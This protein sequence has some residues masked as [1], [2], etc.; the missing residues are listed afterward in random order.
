MLYATHSPVVPYSGGWFVCSV[1]GVGR[2]LGWWCRGVLLSAPLPSSESKRDSA[3]VE[4][5]PHPR[6]PHGD[7]EAT[8]RQ[9]KRSKRKEASEE[10][11]THTRPA[12][13]LQFA[14]YCDLRV[15]SADRTTPID[16]ADSDHQESHRVSK[17][18][19]SIVITTMEH[20]PS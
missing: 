20:S 7:E 9:T 18:L 13:C 5:V 1:S 10:R 17:T 3:W 2:E 15:W 19:W 14:A 8:Q 12:W 11:N 16:H 4:R 6:N